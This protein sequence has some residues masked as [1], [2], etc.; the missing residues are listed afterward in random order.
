MYFV[1][2]ARTVYNIFCPMRHADL[3]VIGYISGTL[4]H[5]GA[6]AEICTHVEHERFEVGDGE[7][8]SDGNKLYSWL[9]PIYLGL[10]SIHM[11]LAPKLIVFWAR[12]IDRPCA[13][14]L[15]LPSSIMRTKSLFLEQRRPRYPE[16]KDF[17]EKVQREYESV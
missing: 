6:G 3:V 12:N 10:G 15:W 14:V 2:I 9:R 1:G 13:V 5:D 8:Y 11:Q 4:H 17:Q 7:V 16:N